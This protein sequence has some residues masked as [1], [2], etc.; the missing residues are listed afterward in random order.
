M[1]RRRHAEGTQVPMH[2]SKQQIETMLLDWGAKAIEFRD[3]IVGDHQVIELRFVWMF[4]D[5][6][7]SACF[8]MAVDEED[9]IERSRH[10]RT[11]EVLSTKLDRNRENWGKETL[12]LLH[13]FLKASLHAVNEGLITAE[14]VFMPWFEDASGTVLS[15]VLDPRKLAENMSAKRLMGQTTR[16]LTS[17][18]E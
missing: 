12:R 5:I 7:L 11:G 14:Q 9:L 1:A 6:P 17:G 16:L 18:G 15:D 2:R 8:K 4:D 13:T 3:K 10:G